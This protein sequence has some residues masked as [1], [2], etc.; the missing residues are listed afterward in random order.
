MANLKGIWHSSAREDIQRAVGL[1]LYRCYDE[2][3][4]VVMV[5]V[6]EYSAIVLDQNKGVSYCDTKYFDENFA[7]IRE[8][9]H[10]EQIQIYAED[11]TTISGNYSEGASS[12]RKV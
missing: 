3:G 10:G 6:N 1:H 9:K 5:L 2:F 8:A 12:P 4:N 7:I 11:P